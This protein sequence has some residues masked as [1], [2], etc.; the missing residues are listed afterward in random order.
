MLK[1]GDPAKKETRRNSLK[2]SRLTFVRNILH[3]LD[4]L[5]TG[6]VINYYPFRQ[7]ETRQLRRPQKQE[8]CKLVMKWPLQN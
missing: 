7:L 4:E 5:A 6:Y 3:P 2:R 1:E 8:G